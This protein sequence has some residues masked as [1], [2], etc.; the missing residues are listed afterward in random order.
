[1]KDN[2]KEVDERP[3]FVDATYPKNEPWLTNIYF[4]RRD[5]S[6]SHAHL[7]ASGAAIIYLRDMNGSEI[8]KND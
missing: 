1:M 6:S 7:V 8:I 3:H 4:G 2:K 5:G